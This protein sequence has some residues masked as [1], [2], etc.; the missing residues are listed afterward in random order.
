MEV[1]IPL[2]GSAVGR[3][4]L[5]VSAACFGR[6]VQGFGSKRNFAYQFVFAHATRYHKSLFRSMQRLGKGMLPRGQ[7]ESVGVDHRVV[8][9]S[10]I[11]CKWKEARQNV[12]RI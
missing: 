8:D 4:M 9:D 6:A 5:K 10:I 3:A 11:V 12:I 7:V 1:G 2:T